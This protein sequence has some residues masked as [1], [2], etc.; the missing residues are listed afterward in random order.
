MLELDGRTAGLS[1][2]E[3]SADQLCSILI[4]ALLDVGFD[5]LKYVLSIYIII[6]SRWM[7]AVGA[8]GGGGLVC[9]S[10]EE[11]E[12]QQGLKKLFQS[13]AESG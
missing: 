6:N 5:S 10:K 1:W 9:R 11:E 8:G 3:Y 12:D 13:C 4:I 7:N 2:A